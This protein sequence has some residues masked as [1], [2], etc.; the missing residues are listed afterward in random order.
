VRIHAAL[1]NDL[2]EDPA[3]FLPPRKD[4]HGQYIHH[5]G[6]EG[7]L[8]LQVGSDPFLQNVQS[9]ERR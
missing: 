1:E 7:Y 2:C 9:G 8:L 3:Q 5:F 6:V 4:A